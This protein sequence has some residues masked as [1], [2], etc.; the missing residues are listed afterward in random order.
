MQVRQGQSAPSSHRRPPGTC[1][2]SSCSPRPSPKT[3]PSP[4]STTSS[5]PGACWSPTWPTSPPAW[6]TTRPST[7]LQCARG[8]DGRARRRPRHIRGALLRL[9]RHR[10]AGIRKS[11]RP[12]SGQVAGEPGDPHR[13]IR[14]AAPS[15][16][17]C[18]ASNL[19]HRRIYERIAAHDPD[20]AAA[21][22]FGHITDAW[23]A[24]RGGPGDALRLHGSSPD[25]GW[26]T[27]RRF[28]AGHP[29]PVPPAGCRRHRRSSLR[30][31][32][33]ST[34]GWW[35]RGSPRSGPSCRWRCR[36]R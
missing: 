19:G 6:R 23:L 27:G 21:A 16:A 8:P 9:P 15:G 1:S 34:A 7:R 26:V 24:R 31:R 5:S 25:P 12:W 2:T 33:W 30:T 36:R 4:S 28:T 29:P 10:H 11:H 13:A 20:G 35:R 14:G 22:M 32:P 18:V 3:T 17:G